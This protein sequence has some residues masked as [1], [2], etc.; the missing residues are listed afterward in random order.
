MKILAI[1]SIMILVPISV[2]ASTPEDCKKISDEMINL[3]IQSQSC[4]QNPAT[5]ICD[6]IEDEIAQKNNEYYN[7]ISNLKS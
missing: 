5:A 3:K 2:L 7:C 6:S 4:E 1:L